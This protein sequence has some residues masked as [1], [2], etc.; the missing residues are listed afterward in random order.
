MATYTTPKTWAPGEVLTASDCNIY[1]RDN[2]SSFAGMIVYGTSIP[3]GFTEYTT[4]RGLFIC[5]VPS[6]GTV[7]TA[8]GTP[9]TNL[10]NVT[11]T[12]TVA[13][14]GWGTG[15]AEES[16]RPIIGGAGAPPAGT[17]HASSAPATGTASAASIGIPYLHL[18][19]LQKSA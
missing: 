12:H 10:Q 1:I 9:L 7:A 18:Y 17:S 4:A 2:T 19:A 5:A 16:G 11:H 3:S 15:G 14:T 8:V 6:G 13:A